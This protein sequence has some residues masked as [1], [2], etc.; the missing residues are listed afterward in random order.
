MNIHFKIWIPGIL[1][2]IAY[3]L[4]IAAERGGGSYAHTIST[5]FYFIWGILQLTAA[6][7]SW[8]L[9]KI[10]HRSG[11]WVGLVAVSGLFGITIIYLI[12]A[13]KIQTPVIPSIN[14]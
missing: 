12:P 7:Y 9:L 6:W 13:K 5:F 4:S 8:Q 11:A 1:S 14:S 10:K 3:I 2:Y